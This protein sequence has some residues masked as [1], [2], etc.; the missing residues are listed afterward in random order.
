MFMRYLLALFSL[1]LTTAAVAQTPVTKL[2]GEET[3][4][5]R[6][7]AERDF[8]MPVRREKAAALTTQAHAAQP[9]TAS[10]ETDNIGTARFSEK[11]DL[12]RDAEAPAAPATKPAAVRHYNRAAPRR[13]TT[14]KTTSRKATTRK[15]PAR[16]PTTKAK[17]VHKAPVRKTAAKKAPV[18]K[19]VV[20]RKR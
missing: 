20:S 8:L 7:R 1:L 11:P 10:P 18:K 5:R 17:T 15:A 12:H 4:S 16:K 14:H 19:K 3:L 2:P 13:T 6:E 9:P